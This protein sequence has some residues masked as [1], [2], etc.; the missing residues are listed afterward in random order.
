[1]STRL[2]LAAL[3]PAYI[4]AP[5][6]RGIFT[7]HW[8]VATIVRGRLAER[9]ADGHGNAAKRRVERLRAQFEH[10]ADAATA[11]WFDARVISESDVDLLADLHASPRRPNFH[12]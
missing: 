12:D 3:V 8:A 5:N 9:N 7:K 11:D 10:A 2:N 4:A 6:P 1:M